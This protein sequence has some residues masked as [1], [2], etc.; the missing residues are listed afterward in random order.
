MIDFVEDFDLSF[1]ISFSIVV[2]ELGFWVDF[3]GKFFPVFIFG[4]TDD[5]VGPFADNRTYVVDAHAFPEVR[6]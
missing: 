5:R 6:L 4:E 1:K 3:D 2:L